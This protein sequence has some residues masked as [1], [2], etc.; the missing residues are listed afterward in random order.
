MTPH[1]AVT[2]LIV[3]GATILLVSERVRLDAVALLVLITL[4]LTGLLTPEQA[5]SGFASPTVIAVASVFVVSAGLFQTGVARRIGKSVIRFSGESEPRL[6]GVLM[7]GVAVL[8]AVMNNVAAVA[9]LLPVVL[10]IARETR[11]PPCRLLLPLAYGAVMGGTLTLVGTPPNLI[12]SDVLVEGG[13]EPLGFFEISRVGVPLVIAGIAFM[14]TLGRSL[15]PRRAAS[16]RTSQT[17]LPEELVGIYHLPEHLFAVTVP[18]GSPVVGQS[19]SQ[20]RMQN[21]FDLTVLGVVRDSQCIVAPEPTETLQAKDCVLVE[22]GPQRVK[23]AVEAWGLVAEKATTSEADLLLAGDVGLVEV[24]LAPRSR[25]EG[26]SLREVHFR[27]KYGVTVLALWRGREPIERNLGDV[28]LRVGDVLL[29]QG[30]WR[31]IRLLRRDP[32]L[33]VLLGENEVPRRTRKAPF[34][35]AILFSMIA[36][37]I[38]GIAPISVAALGAALLLVLTGCLRIE[39]AQHAI[40]WQVVFVIVGMLA[41]GHAM[42]SAGTTQ[43]VARALLSPVARTGA[44]PILA[45]LFV[46]TVGLDLVLSNYAS[47]VLLAPVAMSIAAVQSLEARPLVLV[48]ALAS[49]VAFATPMAHQS[50]LLVMGP[51]EYRF[52]DYVRVGLPLS[53]IAMAVIVLGAWVLW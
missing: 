51:G 47:A 46:V 21:G 49:S 36:V 19:L 18:A 1:I 52:S 50:N 27:E 15:L 35:M 30:S 10:G 33:I 34:A 26:Q 14:M 17:A 37:V 9:V 6:I 28:P 43:W 25:F 44:L 39:E 42:Q 32:E 53:F 40:E 24:T 7:I 8:S 11:I 13:L 22:G 20:C 31:R 29:V 48:V 23:R 4:I 45:V 41:L 38:A 5:F 16:R 12:V 3:A 2:L